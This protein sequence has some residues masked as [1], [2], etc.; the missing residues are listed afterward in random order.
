MKRLSVSALLILVAVTLI[1]SVSHGAREEITLTTIIP[2]QHILRVQKGIVS[3]ANYRP[4]VFPDTSIPAKSLIIEGN[5]GIGTT[6]PKTKLDV[7]G[8]IRTGRYSWNDK[9]DPSDDNKGAIFYNVDDDKMYYSTGSSWEPMGGGGAGFGIWVDVTSIATNGNEA[10]TTDGLVI[11]WNYDDDTEEL[12]GYTPSDTLR[13][14]ERDEWWRTSVDLV[15]P[16]RKGDTW[17]VVGT[18]GATPDKVW[19]ISLGN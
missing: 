8:L 18:A 2:D 10:A 6:A 12:W 17:K 13:I 11:A 4:S 1:V 19:W 15:M 5:I 16:V 9:P 3:E 14:R 7:D